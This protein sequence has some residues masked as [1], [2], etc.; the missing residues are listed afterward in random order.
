ME[1][2]SS[3]VSYDKFMSTFWNVIRSCH[4]FDVRIKGNKR[5]MI[6]GLERKVKSPS[7]CVY[8]SGECMYQGCVVLNGVSVLTQIMIPKHTTFYIHAQIMT[9]TH[10]FSFTHTTLIH[11]HRG[12][13]TRT[14]HVR[15]KGNKRGMIAGLERKV[16]SP[17]I[18]NLPTFL[19]NASKEVV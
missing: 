4:E 15:I 16:K 12:I 19:M 18:S 6:A 9:Y 14:Y 5:G 3:K 17:A 7:I 1:D 2:T 10:H 13:M 8:Q 11:T